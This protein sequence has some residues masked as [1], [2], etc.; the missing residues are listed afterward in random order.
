MPRPTTKIRVRGW[1]VVG[2]VDWVPDEVRRREREAVEDDDDEEEGMVSVVGFDI[3]G[4]VVLETT[5]C[6]FDE[7]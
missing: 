3:V 5:S 2:E 7:G 1:R 6:K 4:W